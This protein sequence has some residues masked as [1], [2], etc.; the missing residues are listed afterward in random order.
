MILE[1]KKKNVFLNS[2]GIIGKKNNGKNDDVDPE[3]LK[4]VKN[5]HLN[6]GLGALYMQNLKFRIEPSY[7][8]KNFKKQIR[9]EGDSNSR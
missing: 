3:N 5:Y 4:D 1:I 8:K 6:M 2:F 9:K 7:I